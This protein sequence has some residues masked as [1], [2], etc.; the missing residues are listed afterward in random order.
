VPPAPPADASLRWLVDRG[1]VRGPLA[2]ADLPHL[3]LELALCL[4][5]REYVRK[6]RI[7]GFA[8]ALSG[9]RDSSMCAVL[10]QRMLRYSHPDLDAAALAEL[11]RRT[12]VT[13]YLAT[14]HSGDATETAA[15]ELAAEIGAEHLSAEIQAAVDLHRQLVGDLVGDA[16]S[17]DNPA[18]DIPLQNVQ[19][20]LRGSLIWFVANL[21]GR[22]LLTTSNKTEAAVGYATMDGDTSGGLA[23]IADVPKSLI[24]PWLQWAMDTHG[25]TSLR[26]V[27]HT[28]ATAELRPASSAQTDEGDLMPFAVLDRLIYHFAYLGEEPVTLFDRLWPEMRPRYADDPRAFATHI[29]KFVRLF[30]A[31]QWKRERF[32]ISFRV[33][34]FDL[35]PKYGFRFP[36][37][38]AP[39][40]EELAA[41]DARVEAWIVAST[42]G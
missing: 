17:W 6:S 14:A 29:R 26:H 25:L 37:V 31:A 39:F 21:K 27:L 13:A 22:L 8:L 4:G 28:P 18:H 15:R 32:A 34:V 41:L 35:D 33:G 24:G 7:P 5:L 12:L 3:E 9:G 1:L 38:Q 23:P 19:A 2:P 42:A 40:T 10:V 20:R 16:P 30:C 11:V 36:P